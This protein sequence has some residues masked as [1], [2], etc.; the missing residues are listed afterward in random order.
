VA[1]VTLQNPPIFPE[2]WGFYGANISQRAVRGAWH[3]KPAM[4][5]L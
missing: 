2:F 4:P 1:F 5:S 3:H